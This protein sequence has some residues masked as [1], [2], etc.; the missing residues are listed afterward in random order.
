MLRLQQTPAHRGESRISDLRMPHNERRRIRSA[1]F[2]WLRREEGDMLNRRSLGGIALMPV[3]AAV[4][5]AACGK[6]EPASQTPAT[7]TPAPAAAPAP[8]PAAAP[9]AQQVQAP[10][11]PPAA[12]P[13]AATPASLASQQYNQNPDLRCDVL[14]VRRVSGGA[15]LVRWRLIRAAAAAA[16][17]LVAAQ[18]PGAIYHTWGW[19]GV[20]FTDP[21]E[22]K[23]Y[24]GLKDSAGQWIGQGD[25]KS[26]SPGDQ[27]V[28][29][30]KFPAPPASSS[31]I[32]FVFPGFPPFEDLLVS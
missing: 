4:F 29:W 6:T 5:M 21:A 31:K 14:E 17:G 30:M 10:A 2:P 11:T 9:A 25:A 12:A 20:Y 15:V 22:N 28:M 23:K 1:T 18:Q 13:Q 3:M 24:L 27:Q 8:A 19:E 32:T 26:Y 7:T 16:G